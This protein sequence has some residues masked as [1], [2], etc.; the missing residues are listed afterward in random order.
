VSYMTDTEASNYNQY[1]DDVFKFDL[2]KLVFLYQGCPLEMNQVKKIHQELFLYEGKI[3][4]EF[5]YKNESI[6]VETNIPQEHHN[7]QIKVKSM[8]KDLQ[9]QLLFL[10]PASSLLGSTLEEVHSYEINDS[11]IRIQTPYI[12]YE[13]F[14]ETNMKRR[15]SIFEVNQKSYLSISLNGDFCDDE[16]MKKY[17]DI[18]KCIDT[19]DAELNRRMVL[20]LYLLKV[21]TLGIYP[22]AE[23]GLT[24]NSWYGKFHLEMHLWHHL[25]LIRFGLYSYVLSSL[26][27]YLSI[28]DSSKRR[29]NEQGY[30]GIRFPKMTDYRGKDTPSNIGC[31]LIWQMPHLFVLLD[32]I[33]KQNPKAILLEEWLPTLQGLIDFMVSFYYLKDGKYHLDSPIIPANEN[34]RYDCDTPIFEE[35]YT[36]HAFE[37]FKR[38]KEEYQWEYDTTRLEDIIKNHVPLEVYNG[39]YEAFIGCKTTY[40][41][42]NFDHPMMVGMFSYFRSS[43]VDPII[44]E[45]TLHKI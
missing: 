7:L 40:A 10:K 29:A 6:I 8:L 42:Y 38:W 4:S 33:L 3:Y 31:L 16:Q 28:Y 30:E 2:F 11:K 22:P 43:I 36:I 14:Y 17:F 39:Y 37:I 25:G 32:E 1:R 23:T 24:C 41:E 13:L 45:N 21:N 9:I 20:S 18:A 26:K 12:S 34:V 15:D 19:E 27:W 44:I 35:C 5:Q